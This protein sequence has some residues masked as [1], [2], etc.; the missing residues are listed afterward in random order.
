MCRLAGRGL[1]GIPP[2]DALFPGVARCIGGPFHSFEDAVR[3][4][5][6]AGRM[7]QVVLLALVMGWLFED[8]E[9]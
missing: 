2:V 6:S 4:A 8:L 3:D 7:V 1:R 9:V 5:L